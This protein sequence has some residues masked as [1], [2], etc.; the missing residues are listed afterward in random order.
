[1]LTKAEQPE[2]NTQIKNAW[3]ERRYTVED[4]CRMYGI[5]RLEFLRII[6]DFEND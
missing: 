2:A 3:K 6:N 4:I 5:S 1:M